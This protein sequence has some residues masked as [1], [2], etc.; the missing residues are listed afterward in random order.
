MP[1]PAE[2]NTTGAPLRGSGRSPNGTVTSSR[3]PTRTFERIQLD[4]SPAGLCPT[5]STGLTA[6]VNS[7]APGAFTKLY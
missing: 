1:I 2:I 5:A 7:A 4:T 3:S 6:K